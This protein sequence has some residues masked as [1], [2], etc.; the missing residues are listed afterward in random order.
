MR[1]ETLDMAGRLDKYI[2]YMKHWSHVG[3][4]LLFRMSLTLFNRLMCDNNHV[5]PLTAKESTEWFE[6]FNSAM[7]E[8]QLHELHKHFNR[9]MDFWESY[10]DAHPRMYSLN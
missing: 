2:E 1:N 3:E 4:R 6:L 9:I 5:L 7:H 10:F 8:K